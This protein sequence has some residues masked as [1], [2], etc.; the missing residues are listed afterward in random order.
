MAFY[1]FFSLI[2]NIVYIVLCLVIFCVVYLYLNQNKMI[3]IP[4]GIDINLFLLHFY[5]HVKYQMHA[6]MKS[7]TTQKST[8]I[9]W[10]GE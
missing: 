2:K 4:E 5:I 8:K 1:D 7:N 3:Y 10:R 6:L 9:L